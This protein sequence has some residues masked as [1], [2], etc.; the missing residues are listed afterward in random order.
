MNNFFND[1]AT[2]EIYTLSLH[3]ALPILGFS[4]PEYWSEL[5]FPSP[6]N[7]PDPGIEPG[8]PALQAD[9]L[10]SEPPGKPLQIL[11]DLNTQQSGSLSLSQLTHL[12]NGNRSPASHHKGLINYSKWLLGSND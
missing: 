1:T 10:L 3:D 6:G 7:L 12:E 11:L 2:T 9:S 8:S 4:R 5:P